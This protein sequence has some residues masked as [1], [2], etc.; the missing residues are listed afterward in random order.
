VLSRNSD[1]SV[2]VFA[3][4]CYVVIFEICKLLLNFLS[5]EFFLL[6]LP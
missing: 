3:S 2:R 4:L 5:S 1:S 6:K